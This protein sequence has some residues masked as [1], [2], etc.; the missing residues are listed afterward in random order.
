MAREKKPIEQ[1]GTVKA[2]VLVACAF[3][4][5]DDVVEVT[6]EQAKAHASEVDPNPEAV[7]YAE[8]LKQ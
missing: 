2:R 4:V 8:S 1:T 7:A 5:P 6:A 3:G